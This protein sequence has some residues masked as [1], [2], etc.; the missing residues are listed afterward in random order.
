MRHSLH[1]AKC[2][3]ELEPPHQQGKQYTETRKVTSGV[4]AHV[5]V[6]PSKRVFVPSSQMAACSE[7]LENVTSTQCGSTVY[8]NSRTTR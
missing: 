8:D 4:A 6:E 2:H 5:Y 7:S 1:D 3:Y